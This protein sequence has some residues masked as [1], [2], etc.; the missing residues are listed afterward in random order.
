MSHFE[1]VVDDSTFQVTASLE[2]DSILVAVGENSYRFKTIGENLFQ[3]NAHD[4]TYVVAAIK[5]HGVFYVDVDTVTLEVREAS[6]F[7][8]SYQ[9]SGHAAVKDKVFA[10]MP[11]KIVKVLVTV[12]D[13]VAEKQPLAVVEAMKMEN[14][15]NSP[16]AGKVKAVHFSVGQQVNTITPIIELE[17]DQK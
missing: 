17:L 8:N 11:G 6:D 13:L 16:A 9:T 2:N 7:Q 15:I 14:Q 1:F 10:P 4:R 12:G 3:A 5:R